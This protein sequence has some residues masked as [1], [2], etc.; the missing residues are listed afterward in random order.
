M[1]RCQCCNG[2]GFIF[3]GNNTYED[4]IQKCDVCNMF[5]NDRAAQSEYINWMMEEYNLQ[6]QWEGE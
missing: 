3:N 6:L 4:E 1:N 2:K 5:K